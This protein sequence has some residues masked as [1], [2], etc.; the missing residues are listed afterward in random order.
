MFPDFRTNSQKMS[1]LFPTYQQRMDHLLDTR[2]LGDKIVQAR[3]ADIIARCPQA[4]SVGPIMS[5]SVGGRS[6]RASGIDYKEQ[7]ER[8]NSSSRNTRDEASELL[9]SVS[10]NEV[11]CIFLLE[12][13][14]S[15]NRDVRDEVKALLRKIPGNL[16][17]SSAVRSFLN[18]DS[19]EVREAAQRL[20]DRM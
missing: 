4:H 20:L 7:L 17:D 1:D 5:G 10:G 9:S 3:I 18:D 16:I 2:S 13:L 19:L 15:P 14:N 6:F 11:D 8:M 12:K